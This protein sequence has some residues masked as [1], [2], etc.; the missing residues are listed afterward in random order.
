MSTLPAAAFRRIPVQERLLLASSVAY[1]G[2]FA[3]LLAFGRPGLGLSQGFYVPV[4]LA[5][6][7]TGAAG[8][9]IA[10]AGAVALLALATHHHEGIAWSSLASSSGL[11]V[12]LLSYVAAGALVGFVAT[13]G[14]RMLSESL[15]ALDDLLALA[16][17][18]LDTGVATTGGLDLAITR[19]LQADEPFTLLVSELADTQRERLRS[20]RLDG[21]AHSARGIARIL[22]ELGPLDEVARVSP[23]QFALVVSPPREADGSAI[24]DEVERALDR[25]G[26][27]ASVGWA[28]YPQ[29]GC[30][31]IALY[32]TAVERLHARL[33]LRGHWRPTAASAGLEVGAGSSQL[34]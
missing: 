20:G 2:V 17:R 27:D 18:D 24:G 12:R 10:G 3:L 1:G 7:A 29:D 34:V 13:R 5:A 30:D 16:G 6:L 28:T 8:G 32:A 4:I 31:S 11:G 26:W 14:R 33:V 25:Q 15:G 19:R 22:A 23:T 21:I 9:A